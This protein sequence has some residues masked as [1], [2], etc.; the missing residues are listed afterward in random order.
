MKILLTYCIL[1]FVI[2]AYCQQLTP[3]VF[4]TAGSSLSIDNL[5]YS[6]TIGQLISP[7]FV[8]KNKLT[9]GFQQPAKL[10]TGKIKKETNINC[11]INAFPNPTTEKATISLSGFSSKIVIIEVYNAIGKKIL[12]KHIN[13]ADKN[14]LTYELDLSALSNGYYVVRLLSDDRKKEF[15]SV[16]LVKQ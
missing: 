15:A 1:F 12:T 5:N 9:Q 7:T 14:Y 3:S 8:N 2:S 10:Y 16:N 13:S 11:S 4:S 6:Y